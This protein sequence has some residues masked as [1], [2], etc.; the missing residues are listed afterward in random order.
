MQVVLEWLRDYNQMTKLA[1]E[2]TNLNVN[3]LWSWA[4][5]FTQCAKMNKAC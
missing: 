2:I 1:N 3:C 4:G 5:V